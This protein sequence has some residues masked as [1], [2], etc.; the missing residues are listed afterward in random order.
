MRTAH[1]DTGCTAHYV[2]RMISNTLRP[3]PVLTTERLS[4]SAPPPDM[5][6]HIAAYYDQNRDHHG[7]WDPPRTEAFFS[8][9]YWRTQLMRNRTEIQVGSSYK[10]FLFER[11]HETS[12]PVIGSVNMT[13]IARGSF[14]AANVGYSLG[15]SHVG[16]GYMTEALS[17]VIHYAFHELRLHRLMANYQP[18]NE[19]SGR[20]LRRLG[21]VVEGYARDYLFVGGHWADHILTA[22]TSPDSS[23]PSP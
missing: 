8:E 6:P 17:A 2:R 19:R 5:A 10:L 21:F 7:P 18:T 15:V 22:L 14:N 23:P 9:Q 20:V 4:I 16:Q 11:G 13:N 1:R 3:L 12:G